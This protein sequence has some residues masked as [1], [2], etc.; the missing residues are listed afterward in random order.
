[1]YKRENFGCGCSGRE[2]YEDKEYTKEDI[3]KEN[4]Q[5]G[6]YLSESYKTNKGCGG[7]NFQCGSNKKQQIYEDYKA[8]PISSCGSNK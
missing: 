7:E 5:C 1:M 4:F 3:K 2:S 8:K 6:K